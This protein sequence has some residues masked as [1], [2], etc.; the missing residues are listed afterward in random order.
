[1]SALDAKRAW[2]DVWRGTPGKR[3]EQRYRRKHPGSRR[4][5]R[6]IL[7]IV[8]GLLVLV[9]GIVMLPA[10]GP[11]MVVVALGAG[12][13]AQASLAAARALDWC[14]LRIRALLA[15]ARKLWARAGTLARAAIL[16]TGLVLAGAGAY[17]TWWLTFGR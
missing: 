6:K 12:I 15:W 8:V 3:F 5:T 7:T 13:V 14:E 17:G 1:M 10:P 11:G 16:L 9:V 4:S 2:A